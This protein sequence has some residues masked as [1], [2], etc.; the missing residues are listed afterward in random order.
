MSALP[1]RQAE[2]WPRKPNLISLPTRLQTPLPTPRH[3]GAESPL[4]ER[5]QRDV[6]DS[7]SL[8]LVEDSA[9]DGRLVLE[10]LREAGVPW[11]LERLD[12]V[13]DAEA[14]VRRHHVDCVLLDLGVLDADGLDGLRRLVA[15]DAELP[16]VVLTRRDDELLSTEALRHGAQD[17]LAKRDLEPI[18]LTRAVRY[19]IE[20]K[21]TELQVLHLANHDSLTGVSNR[22]LLLERL[23]SSLEAGEA[24]GLMFV[25][26]D[27]LKLVNDS[28][29]HD[30]GDKLLSAVATRMQEAL[31]PSDTLGRFGGDE[32][33]LLYPGMTDGAH[34]AE[35]AARLMQ[36]VAQPLLL[37]TRV[38]VPSVS[39]GVALARPGDPV[40]TDA[41]VADADLAL[42]QAKRRG[43]ARVEL[44]NPTMR[45]LG[46]EKLQLL[47]ELRTAFAEDQFTV[48]FQPQ[49]A[50]STGKLVAVEALLRWQHPTRGLLPA[51]VFFEV[52]EDSDMVAT[53]GRWVMEQAC[54]AL[55]SW[56]GAT[57]P[58]I[59]VNISPRHISLP[60]FGESMQ[61][62][63]DEA[64]VSPH[65]IE[66]EVTES[67]IL[68]DETTTRVL[69]DLHDA[70]FRLAVDDF[71]T[72]YSSLTHLKLFPASTVK[73][74]R[75]FVAGLGHDRVDDAIIR[76]VLGV[77]DSLGLTTVG[78]GIEKPE[79]HA[80]LQSLGC[81]LGQGHLYDRALPLE[82]LLRRYL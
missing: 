41:L 39:V 6:Q 80:T 4:R 19:A 49:V 7:L 13:A 69:H 43:K 22:A 70:G 15:V 25:D 42:Y 67:A 18:M 68:V 24:L 77:A 26:V 57:P 81:G 30:A 63:A 50:L 32:F 74:D 1:K 16:L 44:F 72:G 47:G 36:Q 20:R 17:Y 62:I 9:A 48:H 38:Y 52:I 14:Y 40:T 21:A 28:Y 2:A 60:G 61:R 27:D 46:G 65:L 64:G 29:G 54:G 73:I 51:A 5:R 79:Q 58:R 35:V 66:L 34:A 55:A 82:E 71:G 12:R 76:A 3:S 78:E 53:V 33:A 31:R 37:G 45:T 8:L 59:A 11:Q 10:L 56:P 23:R 75:S